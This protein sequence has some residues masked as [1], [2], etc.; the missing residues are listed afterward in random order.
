VITVTTGMNVE[1]VQAAALVAL[2]NAWR[3]EPD[4][5]IAMMKLQRCLDFPATDQ[6]IK[7][8]NDME[9]AQA[10]S[11]P[12]AIACAAVATP[13]RVT[14]KVAHIH[15]ADGLPTP[16]DEIVALAGRGVLPNVADVA[17]LGKLSDRQRGWIMTCLAASGEGTSAEWFS[18]V[19]G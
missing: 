19:Q 5:E 15:V 17:E 3:S 14:R 1:Q 12:V 13:T 7:I 2:R 4:D 8:A 18:A 9:D 16:D 11:K 6:I 10:K